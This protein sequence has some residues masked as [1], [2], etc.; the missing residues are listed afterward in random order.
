MDNQ[1]SKLNNIAEKLPSKI[2]VYMFLDAHS[3]YLYIG[4]SESIKKRVKTHLQSK[5]IKSIQFLKKTQK[6][7]FLLTDSPQDALILESDLIK[8]NQPRYNISLKD[9]KTYPYIRITKEDY[10]KI[11]IV[12]IKNID[13]ETDIVFGPYTEVSRLRK[14]LKIIHK[15][16]YIR[17]CTFNITSDTIKKKKH[18][19]CLDYHIGK[20]KAPC[21][22]L[23]S[24]EEYNDSIKIVKNI[25]LGKSFQI[26]EKFKKKMNFYSKQY[27]YEKAATY[28][29]LIEDVKGFSSNGK[30][31]AKISESHDYIS[32]IR[33]KN[34]SGILLL[35]VR[36]G[37]IFSNDFFLLKRLKEDSDFE[38]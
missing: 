16:G 1:L 6:I 20:C 21:E 23:I 10:P 15:I 38:V 3:N 12:R 26:I 17:T 5:N 29:D 18:K 13:L 30:T 4:K 25:L 32:L 11:E 37:K 35:K 9:D 27:M 31:I 34:I 7:D 8:N 14:I 28:R 19:V 22:G 36:C 2:G 33:K 24:K